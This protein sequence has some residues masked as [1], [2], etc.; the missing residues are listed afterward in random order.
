M[1]RRC[2][3]LLRVKDTEA[4]KGTL[5]KKI[6]MTIGIAFKPLKIEVDRNVGR[7][8]QNRTVQELK[9]SS[10]WKTVILQ[11]NVSSELKYKY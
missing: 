1:S 9:Q 5:L 4:N 11:T 7:E 6:K 8:L 3:G 10:F 2:I